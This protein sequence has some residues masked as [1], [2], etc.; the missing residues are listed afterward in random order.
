MPSINHQ[1]STH[2]Q[3]MDHVI[4]VNFRQ[5]IGNAIWEDHQ[6]HQANN[7]CFLG[8]C[9]YG[10][11]CLYVSLYLYICMDLCT[12]ILLKLATYVAKIFYLCC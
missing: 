9:F 4:M 12:F 6:Q 3:E 5:E 11:M 1:R 10:A 7:S 2:G 8:I